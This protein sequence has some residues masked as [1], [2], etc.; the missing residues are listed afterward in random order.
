VHPLS[1]QASAA[2]LVAVPLVATAAGAVTYA[3][4]RQAAPADDDDEPEVIEMPQ[5]LKSE[6]SW[7]ASAGRAEGPEGYVFG[8]LTRGVAVRVF[9]AKNKV[10]DEEIEAQG[11][12]QH[13]QVQRL[14]NDAIK[15]YRARGYKGSINMSHTVAYFNESV[16][17]AVNGPAFGEPAP[18]Q[19]EDASEDAVASAAA[20]AA[21]DSDKAE[22]NIVK[23]GQAGLV[24]ATL[25]ARL[26][27]RAKSWQAL[28][29]EEHVDPS[30]TQ[31][32]QIG[33]AIPVVKLGWGVSVSLTVS[34]SSLLRWA[35][36]VASLEA[37]VATAS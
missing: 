7:K 30:L 16:S 21:D 18:W 4:R 5:D 31:S 8:D 37:K 1:V 22:A 36:H 17:V 14:L 15:L 9:G 11:D 13:S 19:L 2:M 6:R 33:F 35:E 32:A 29:G 28:S 12:S 26:E 10:D 24:F 23:E 25:L 20:G 3:Y 27:R 34:S